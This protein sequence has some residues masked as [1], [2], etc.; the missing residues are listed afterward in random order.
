M[1]FIILFGRKYRYTTISRMTYT[2]GYDG[3]AWFSWYSPPRS[4]PN[5]IAF[6]TASFSH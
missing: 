1:F 6:L 4:L 3:G 5:R 2:P